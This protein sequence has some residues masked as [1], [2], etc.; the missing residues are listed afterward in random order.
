MERP[1]R[2]ECLGLGVD[3]LA[4]AWEGLVY[5]YPPSYLAQSA[6]E[7]AIASRQLASTIIVLYDWP[8]RPW[9]A[10][11]NGFESI[12]L[13]PVANCTHLRLGK[14]SIESERT[15]QSTR[16]RAWFIPEYDGRP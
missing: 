16:L 5:A 4:H 7:K 14:R 1:Q 12:E 2:D 6:V 11:L 15:W 9:Y 13:G 10:L 8:A 3:A